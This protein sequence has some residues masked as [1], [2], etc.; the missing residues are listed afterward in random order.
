MPPCPARPRPAQVVSVDLY[1]ADR[2]GGWQAKVLA[3]LA[4]L[5]DEG[6]A[7]FPPDAMQQ[8]RTRLG[9]WCFGFASLC[10]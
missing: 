7:A 6:V 1:V 5:F 4:A 8:A 3:C 2:F 9:V 10:S